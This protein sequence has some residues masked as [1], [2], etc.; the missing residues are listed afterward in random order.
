AEGPPVGAGSNREGVGPRCNGNRSVGAGLTEVGQRTE[1]RNRGGRGRTASQTG[2]W[3]WQER[4]RAE[5]NQGERSP[6]C[7]EPAGWG[8]FLATDACNSE[9]SA[10][11]PG[12]VPWPH[13]QPRTIR[14]TRKSLVLSSTR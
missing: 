1:G 13:H 6:R 5:E 10:T 7:A 4:V 2:Q 3:L 8:R 14:C 11:L 12:V 9:E